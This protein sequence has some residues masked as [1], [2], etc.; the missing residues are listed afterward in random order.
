MLYIS[1]LF[2]YKFKAMKKIIY[3]LFAIIFSLSAYSQEDKKPKDL[4]GL[5]SS[6]FEKVNYEDNYTF[7][8]YLTYNMY[9]T[10]S[11]GSKKD[12]SKSKMM[13][14]SDSKA[15]GIK[16][17]ESDG[18]PMENPPIMIFDIKNEAMITLM[19]SDKGEKSGMAIKLKKEELDKINTE[20]EDRNASFNKTS[21]TRMIQGYK[22]TKYTGE[23]KDYTFEFWLTNDL[24]INVA[25][26]FAGMFSR[27]KNNSFTEMPSG[28]VLL[29]HSTKKKNGEKSTMEVVDIGLN[30]NSNFSTAAYNVQSLGDMMGK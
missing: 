2:N 13:F 3:L 14:S 21:E 25:E 23:D 8:K 20:E 10:T 26:A 28:T 6:M 7:S 15:I 5:M 27:Q 16:V 19:T 22:C 1:T 4:S 30:S 17:L 29:G 12:E 24:D 18:K 9:M 11:K